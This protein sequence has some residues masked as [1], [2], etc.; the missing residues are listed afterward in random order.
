MKG[1]GPLTALFAARRAR[2]SEAKGAAPWDELRCVFKVKTDKSRDDYHNALKQIVNWPTGW[3]PTIVV[4][5]SH[6]GH[7][8]YLSVYFMV[9]HQPTHG[10]GSFVRANLG[11]LA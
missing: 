10:A 2:P 6:K 3:K 8:G 11:L 9:D 7:S 1:L 5:P 4:A